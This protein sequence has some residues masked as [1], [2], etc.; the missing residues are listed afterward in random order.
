MEGIKFIPQ[1]Q[2]NIDIG[3]V[4]N[5]NNNGRVL[6]LWLVLLFVVYT[7][8]IGSIY[9]FLIVQK[10]SSISQEIIELD[11]SN[12]GYYIK[13]ISL[14]D[15]LFNFN[16]LISNF[17]DPTIV[18]KAIESTYLSDATVNSYKYDKSTKTITIA[19]VAKSIGDVTEQV[20]RISSLE[21][22]AKVEF[23]STSSVGGSSD[24][25]F[26]LTIILN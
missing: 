17:Y 26:T 15:I 23:P 18:T 12:S 1:N 20:R 11:N 9:R 19:M 14:N 7:I 25:A 16:N 10:Q 22:V 3:I 8:S 4:K 5:T 24:L 13:D 6:V 2:H 21:G